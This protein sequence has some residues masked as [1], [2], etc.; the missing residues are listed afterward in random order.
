[1]RSRH[2]LT[3][4]IALSSP[5]FATDPQP[6]PPSAPPQPQNVVRENQPTPLARPNKE[7]KK[8]G[9]RFVQRRLA[10]P[11]AGEGTPLI[12]SETERVT[13]RPV[14]DAT[15]EFEPGSPVRSAWPDAKTAWLVRD[16]R[17]DGQ[18]ASGRELFGSFTLVGGTA[19]RAE[20]GFEA[21]AALDDDGDGFV[22]ARDAAFDELRLW[23]DRDGDRAASPGELEP[24]GA[25]T[26]L[27]TR[28]ERVL[29]RDAAGNATLERARLDDGRWLLDLHLVLSAPARAL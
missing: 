11:F 12:V 28:F 23:F 3:L 13:L 7:K 24:L 4:A 16:L 17:N 26:R 25:S 18:I 1:M 19:R 8:K 29:R 22:S 10:R 27:P 2:A 9:S 21:L 14:G 6:P 5:V 15:F 20:Q